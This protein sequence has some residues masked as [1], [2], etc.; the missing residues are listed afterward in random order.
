MNDLGKFSNWGRGYFSVFEEENLKRSSA[1][2]A[3]LKAKQ[4]E[5]KL[6]KRLR[7]V[8]LDKNTV[9]IATK[10]YVEQFKILNNG[11]Y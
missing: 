4:K 10:N 3:L 9:V 8:R 5:K 1:E 7:R 6:G 2:E 11:K